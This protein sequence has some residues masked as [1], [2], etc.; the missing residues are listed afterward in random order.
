MGDQIKAFLIGI[1][2]IVS[3]AITAWLVLFLKPSFGDGKTHITVLFPNVDKIDI[4]TRVTFAGRPVGEVKKIKSIQDPRHGPVSS[5]GELYIY[6]LL[7]HVDSSI[8][9]YS[10]DEIVFASAGLLGEKS[11]EI[12]PRATP[13]DSPP[14]KEITHDLLFAS[15]SDRLTSTLNQ[16]TKVACSFGKAMEA[17]NS[18]IVKNDENFSDALKSVTSLSSKVESLV[19]EVNNIDFFGR[20]ALAADSVSKVMDQAN[21]VICDIQDKKIVDQVVKITEKLSGKDSSL[22]RLINDDL[23]YLQMS[24]LISSADTLF[25]YINNYGILFQF[26]KGWQRAKANLKHSNQ[27]YSQSDNLTAH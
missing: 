15:S 24:G 25:N 1:F 5:C 26:S 17:L 14:P 21:N 6:E 9:I 3:I 19:K 10:Y 8:H 11:V 16:F 20:G 4:G 7:L 27:P 2:I 23:F 18:F 12:M 13:K 22:G